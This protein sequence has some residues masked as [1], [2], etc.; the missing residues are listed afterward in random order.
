[1]TRNRRKREDKEKVR[2]SQRQRGMSQREDK[3]GEDWVPQKEDQ[4]DVKV[5]KNW[6]NTIRDSGMFWSSVVEA[7]VPSAH[8]ILSHFVPLAPAFYVPFCIFL[9]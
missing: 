5:T 9:F 7:S 2:G 1:M 3:E 8:L 6:R 4:R